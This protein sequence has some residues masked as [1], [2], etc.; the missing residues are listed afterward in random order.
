M[1]PV[2]PENDALPLEYKLNNWCAKGNLD[3]ADVVNNSVPFRII[4]IPSRGLEKQL[5]DRRGLQS[6]ALPDYLSDPF[7][8]LDHRVETLP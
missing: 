1:S 4:R 5:I 7:L 6:R 3:L 8:I 2:L